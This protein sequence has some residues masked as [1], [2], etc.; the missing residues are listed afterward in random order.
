MDIR[1]IEEKTGYVF[2]N[3][4]LLERAL[5]LSSYSNTF[6]NQTLEF[7]GDAV[8]EFIV[9]EVIFDI[10][11][12][13]GELTDRRK[14]IVSDEALTPVTVKLGLDKYLL[15]NVGDTNNKKAVPSVYEAVVAAIYLDGGM[16]EAKKFVKATLDFNVK[17]EDKNYKGR[18]Q[19]LLAKKKIDPPD[20][21]KNTKDVGTLQNPEFMTEITVEGNAFKG[22]AGNKQQAQQNAAKLALEYLTNN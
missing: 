10:D 9:S 20:Y 5:T 8:L 11:G 21:D 1:A 6:N 13:E 16:D 7:F 22:V 2:K 14:A 4:N 15:K 17:S 12:S 18:L 3:K 19:E